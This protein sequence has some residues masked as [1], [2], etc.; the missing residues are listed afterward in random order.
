MKK[1][2][3]YTVICAKLLHVIG[4]EEDPE[5]KAWVKA[6]VEGK[7]GLMEVEKISLAKTPL[8]ALRR[9]KK[10]YEA[11][12]WGVHNGDIREYLSICEQIKALED[13]EE[14]KQTCTQSG[15]SWRTGANCQLQVPEKGEKWQLNVWRRDDG[16]S[17]SIPISKQVAKA[18]LEGGMG[19]EG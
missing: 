13:E 14:A 4:I 18:L 8:T 9:D 16:S 2:N 12:K 15:I 19:Y 1:V 10:G 11:G 6:K 3:L 5:D 17:Y 7:R